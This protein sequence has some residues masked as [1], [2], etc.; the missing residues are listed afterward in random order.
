MISPTCK[1]CTGPLD[2]RGGCAICEHF[3]RVRQARKVAI[4]RSYARPRKWKPIIP[5]AAN[6]QPVAAQFENALPPS[7]RR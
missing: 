7:D 2:E 5:K 1:N 3:A 6:G 4:L